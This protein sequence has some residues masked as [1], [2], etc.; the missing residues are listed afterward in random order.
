MTNALDDLTRPAPPTAVTALVR[1][2]GVVLAAA[3]TED[4][5]VTG[6]RFMHRP[7]GPVVCGGSSGCNDRPP[8]HR[9]YAYEAVTVD[10]WRTSFPR[11]ATPVH[12]PNTA[13][14]LR[15]AGPRLMRRGSAHAYRAVVS[16]RDGD[17][18]VIRW[19]VDGKLVG[20]RHG[21]DVRL[22]HPGRVRLEA[23]ADD[24]HGAKVRAKL[25]VLL[26]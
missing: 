14:S 11:M 3:R 26:R 25:T 16:D 23:S 22:R 17:H 24:G 19:S 4:P 9:T 8:G 6:V 5:R 15:I 7:G 2:S 13:P 10:P 1:R 18:V 21:I 20:T 12:V